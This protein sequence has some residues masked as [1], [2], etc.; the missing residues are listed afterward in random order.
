MF[1]RQCLCVCSSSYK[2]EL[3]LEIGDI[4]FIKDEN[5]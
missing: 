5:K 1:N 3:V 4:I 2:E